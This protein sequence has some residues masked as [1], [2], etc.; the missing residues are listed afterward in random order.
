MHLSSFKKLTLSATVSLAAIAALPSQAL[1]QD[2]GDSE[3]EETTGVGTIIVTAQRRDENV[4]DVPIAISAF[5]QEALEARG[6]ANALEVAQFVPNLVGLNNTGLGTANAYYLRGIGN[7]ESIATFDPPIGTYVDD[8]YLSRQNANNLSLFDVNRV[9]VL[10]GPQGTLFGRNTTG[11]AVNVYMNDPGDEVAGF[12]EIG[13]GSYDQIMGRASIDIP[14]ADSFSIKVSGYFQDDD[15]YAINNLADDRT[16]ENDGWGVRLGL[17]GELSDSVTWKGSYIRTFA[18]SANVLNFDCDPT[19]PTNCD[20][21]FVST[22]FTEDSNLISPVFGPLLTGDK[23]NFGLGNEAT[24]DFVSSNLEVGIGDDWAVNIITGFVDIKQDFAL[25]FAD[26]RGLPSA[27]NPIPPVT[28]FTFGGFTIANEGSHTQFTQEIKF[29]GS[30]ADGLIDIVGGVFYFYEDNRTDFGDIFSLNLGPGGPPPDGFPLLLADRVIDNTAEAWAGYAQ[31]DVNLTDRLTVTAGIRYTDETKTFEI[32]DNRPRLG[33]GLC[34]AANQFGPSTCIDSENLVAANG[35]VIPREQS[36][37][38]F[39]PRFAIN[40]QLDDILLFA[41][42]TRGFKSGGWNARGTSPGEL[43][44]FG[45]ETA[46]SYEAG[47]K[48]DLFGNLVRLNVTAFWLDVSDL[49]APSAFIRNDG[50][51]AFLTRNFADYENR[52]LEV[53]LTTVPV[54][55]LNL[56]A[57]LGYQDDEYNIDQNAPALDEFG[58]QSVAAQQ[59]ACLSQLAAGLIPNVSGPDNAAACGVGIVSPDGSLA[60][61]VRTPEFTIAFGGSYDIDLGDFTFRPFANANWRSDSEVGTSELTLFDQPVT[62]PS[63]TVFPANTL[64]LGDPIDP[65]SGSFSEARWIVNGGITLAHTGGISVT[66]ECRNCFD[67]EAVESAL[68][69]FSYLNPPR[70]WIVRAKF[71]F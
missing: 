36:V 23:A 63:G 50:S 69:N 46:W 44:P 52:G 10:R 32:R 4:Q 66:A 39:T 2:T 61:P 21:R 55:G 49:Q 43:L 16:N 47:F 53:E 33:G 42:A 12:A 19:D 59:A 41:S 7:T 15:G 35:R 57:S 3:A 1:A 24:M 28:G 34:Q 8:I 30:I 58:V 27:S 13:Y 6:I 71:D 17:R 22:G 51:L 9:E 62:G 45:P 20:G 5:N 70:T 26:G 64:G 14:L 60:E 31:A 65:A 67:E 29:T 40:Y 68:A 37:D 25:D 38:L 48:S 54:D 18:D 11:G 56:F